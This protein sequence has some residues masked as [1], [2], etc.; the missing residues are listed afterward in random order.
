MKNAALAL[1]VMLATTPLYALDAYPKTSIA[2][3]GTATWCQYCPNAYAGLDIVHSQFDYAKFISVRHYETSGSY[4]TPET[5]ARN[6]FNGVSGLPT[7]VF[8][9]LT[10]VVGAGTA[11]AN[12]G[13]PYLTVI[14]GS[15]LE[16]SPIRLEIDSFN[17]S[18]GAVSATVTMYSNTDALVSD[19]VLFILTEDDVTTQHTHVTRD[20][21]YETVTLSGAGSSTTINTSFV[22]DPSWNTANLHAAVL[23]QRVADRDV[24]QAASTYALPDYSVHGMVPFPRVLFG[25][26]SGTFTSDD[27]TI[28]NLGLADTYTIELVV[29][30]S[31]PGWQVEFV[32]DLGGT[33]TTPYVF[34]L[35]SETS[36]DFHIN[37][38][39]T[40]PGQADFHFEVTSLNLSSP[41]VIPFAYFTEGLDIMLV[42]DDGGEN[43]DAYFTAILDAAGKSYGIWNRD[44]SPLTA[45]V[46]QN[47]DVIIWNVGLSYPTLDADDQAF[48]TG[49]LDA[50]KALFVTGQDIGWELNNG[51]PSQ[52]Y[53]DYLHAVYVRD[54]TN[55]MN[56]DG[57]PGDP[58]T[59]GLDLVITGGT[60]ASNQTYPDEIA[61][62]D[63]D[64]TEILYYTGGY[65][66]AVRSQD[67]MT[68]ARV[69]YL[70]FGFEGIDNDLDRSD[71][72]LNAL[73]W[74][75]PEL[76][77]DGFETGDTSVWSGVAP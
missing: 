48:L 58:V 70:G 52:W 64:A 41:V 57:V 22:I 31:P 39:P 25:P 36:T 20:L 53:Q 14:E 7:V 3:D 12:T 27:F 2:E 45:E 60:G 13:E 42:D 16:P 4:G 17:P 69:V 43:Y 77:S 15:T 72:L 32:D 18:T 61:A 26:S 21:V 5:D 65:C 1:I 55:I 38:M 8:D 11:T 59:N 66:G 19:T 9:G 34:G 56:L 71:L 51:G 74:I 46:A 10:K 44:L 49:Y 6:D 62:A 40:S 30:S 75:G 37:V 76:F 50:G 63:A 47:F 23:V 67:S 24:L 29:D 68:R 73:Q 54:D 35:A 33:H 28:M